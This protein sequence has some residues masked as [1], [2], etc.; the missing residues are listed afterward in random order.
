MDHSESRLLRVLTLREG[1]AIH[2]GCIIG[3]GI[4]LKPAIIAGYLDAMAPILLVWVVAGLLTLFGALSIAELSAVLP[5][6]GGPYVY[7]RESFGR[8]WGFLYS[9]NDFFIN[10]A[11]SAAAVAIA[12]ATFAG[13][14]IPA[15]GPDQA[16]YRASISLAG[17]SF[18]FSVGWNQVVAMGVIAVVT[19]VNVRGVQFGGWV[20]NIFTAAKLLALVGL[21][22]AALFSGKG[23]ST[24]FLPWWPQEITSEYFSAFGLALISALWAYDGWLTVTL[25]AGEFKNPR[26]DLPISLIAGTLIVIAVYLAANVA[27]AYVIPLQQMAASSRIAADVAITVLGPIGASLV[28]L[29]IMCST[30]GTTNGQLL[31]GPRTLYAG[32]RDGVFPD[33]FGRVH[34]RYHTPHT[35]IITLG[36]WGMILTFSGTF[37]Q[38]TNYV[39]FT[40]WGFY[41]LTALAVIVLR[42]K[43]P[44]AERPYKA[45]GY[46][47]ATIAFV[48]V[49]LWFL[50]NVVVNQTRDAIVGVALLLAGLPLYF[51]WKKRV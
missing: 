1:I 8:V 18:D 20:M 27:F 29:G 17:V 23:A 41:A 38:I 26:R 6:T 44:H 11:G 39:V 14:F 37:D 51:M 49:T 31:S 35:A 25:N 21:T 45:W 2:I 48:A 32:G 16:F 19:L 22:L 3:S 50:S 40:S 36:L 47:F 30:F 10:K 46:P 43:L 4:F 15:L 12:F 33:L 24:N 34:P 28:I 5:Q 7:L 9:W 42:R 13:H